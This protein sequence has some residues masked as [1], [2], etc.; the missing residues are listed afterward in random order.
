MAKLPIYEQQTTMGSVR[1]DAQTFGAGVGQAVA[2]AGGVMAD[3]GDQIMRRTETIEMAK[4]GREIDDWGQQSLNALNDTEDISS[5]DTVAKFEAGMREK[6]AEVLSRFS[7]RSG[8]RAALQASLENQTYQYVK[9]A[10]AAQIKAQHQFIASTVEQTANA[11][12]LKAADAPGQIDNIFAELDAQLTQ[13]GPAM[14]PTDAEAYRSA[15]REK[16]ATNAL[17]RL[18]ANGQYGTAKELMS[19]PDV[20][21]YLSPDTT[22]RFTIDIAVDEGKA[23]AA[24][25][26]EAQRIASWGVRLGRNLTAEE[27]IKI[28][29]LPDKKDMTV[30]DQITE[31]ELVTSKPVT[32]DVVDRFYKL[33]GAGSGASGM[34]G[35]SLQGR[36]L[37]FVTENAI[38]YA[39]GLLPPEQARQYE[40]AYAEAYK[41]TM[42]PNP[43]TGQMEPLQPTIPNFVAQAMEQGART[44]GGVN[45]T[46]PSS[47][48]GVMPGQRIELRDN[49]GRVIG[50]TT[51]GPDGK[52]TIRDQ[53]PPQEHQAGAPAAGG[54]KTI[55]EMAPD[56]AGPVP[57]IK[58]AAGDIPYIGGMMEGGGETASNR[59]YV[60]TQ[61]SQMVDALSINPRNPVALVEM[62][63]KEIDVDP[64]VLGDP[65]AYRKRI[66]G[67]NRSLTERLA[68]ETAAGANPDLPAKTR[69]DAL[70]VANTIRN[71]QQ[72]LMPP[73]VKN[74]KELDALGLPSGSK[75]IDPNGVLRQIP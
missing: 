61:V 6:Q 25:R 36:S 54:D 40:A 46:Q 41:P 72:K 53:N 70:D 71:F 3:I 10:K 73:Q 15:G 31:Y 59:A 51:V 22:R 64:K 24:A 27:V 37:A 11:L 55:W 28:K 5:P 13:L 19:R 58:T 14:S 69:Q 9:S 43:V 33:D 67:I 68:E 74:R 35:N 26:A 56:L 50:Q 62:I 1:A 65:A 63:R 12:A 52:W 4:M 57:A 7:G 2:Q 23:E 16:L 18:Q 38:A 44:Y 21:R 48:G 39:N 34:F 75:F 66:E 49:T 45:L 32:Q 29:A 17:A 47:A 20:A 60:K 8:A 42:R 30:A